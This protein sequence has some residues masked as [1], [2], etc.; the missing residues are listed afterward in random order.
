MDIFT[1]KT[2]SPIE[3]F[4]CW[5]YCFNV[6]VAIT[7]NQTFTRERV[8]YFHINFCKCYLVMAVLVERRMHSTVC[9]HVLLIS[10]NQIYARR[11]WWKN[12]SQLIDLMKSVKGGNRLKPCSFNIVNITRPPTVRSRI[13]ITCY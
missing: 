1:I 2:I 7:L 12:V 3:R 11:R 4:Y 9:Y 13:E 6:G 8:K 10:K 5:L